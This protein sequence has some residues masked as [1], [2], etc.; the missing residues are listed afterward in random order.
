MRLVDFCIYRS[1]E[2]SREPK[3][4][5]PLPLFHRI[6]DEAKTIPAITFVTFAGLAEPLL[7]PH[8]VDRVRYAKQANPAWRIDLFTNGVYLTPDLFDTLVQAGLGAL[9]ISL[10]ATSPEQHEKIMGLKGKYDL[11][12]RHAEYAIANKGSCHVSVRAVWDGT[13]F[14]IFD[15]HAFAEKW[16]QTQ[17]GTGCGDLITEGNWMNQ[18]GHTT[19]KPFDPNSRCRRAVEQISVHR[20]GRVNACCLDPLNK[21]GWG[22]LK[23]QTIR[24]VYNSDAYVKFREAHAF[25][26]AAEYDF[27]ATCT[28]I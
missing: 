1:A 13:N 19:T 5:M 18:L 3:S 25:N 11:V 7:D 26:R 10:N 27:C 17:R 23:K 6:I 9:V 8:I 12:C 21:H 28:R 16:G 20:D 2:N 22:D 24:E 14:G 15:A 4:H